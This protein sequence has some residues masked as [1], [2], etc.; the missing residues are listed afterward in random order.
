MISPSAGTRR[1][2]TNSC[3]E[4]CRP[5]DGLEPG[6]RRANPCRFVDFQRIGQPLDG[7]HSERLHRDEAFYEFKRRW[8]QQNAARVCELFHAR[9]QVRRPADGRVVHVQ[10][11]ADGAHD[12]LAGI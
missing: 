10:I 3:R 4:S 6:P 8:R 12:N 5:G 11:A 1:S 9:S 7:H 2:R